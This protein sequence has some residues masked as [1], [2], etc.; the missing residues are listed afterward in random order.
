[1]DGLPLV[2][3]TQQIING[4]SIGSIYA[5]IAVGYSLVFGVLGLINFAH[6]DAYMFSTFAVLAMILAGVPFPLAVLAGLVLAGVLAMMIERVA[7]RPLRGAHRMAP[8]V[9]AVGVALILQNL[10]QLIWGPETRAFPN[11][12]PQGVF[13]VEGVAIPELAL[14][15]VAIAAAAG[16]LV[17]LITQYT[18]WGRSMRAIR[19]DL[20]T[21]QLMGIEVNRIISVVYA[22]GG[23]LGVL[24]GVLFAAYYN[25]V[26]LGMGFTGTLYAFTAAVIGGIGSLRGAFV[27]GIALGLLQALAVTFIS[28]GYTATVTFVALIILLIVRPYGLFGTPTIRRA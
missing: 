28:S 11:P 12:L 5:L 21:A 4:L 25:T 1:M 13:I 23:A 24:G 10:T 7:Y 26:Y 18:G 17:A 19:D 27:G 14:A 22:L 16:L 9:S 8:T 3:L 2:S 20:A 6:G 15:V